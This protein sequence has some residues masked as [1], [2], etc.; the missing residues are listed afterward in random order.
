MDESGNHHSQQTGTRTENGTPHV[1]THRLVSNNENTRNR[2]GRIT[3]WGLL[4]RN[5]GGTM[6][7]GRLE[8]DNM[9]RNA[10]YR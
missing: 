4:G 3:H 10:R 1:L 6:G 8:R 5:K 2:V 7:V 9:G